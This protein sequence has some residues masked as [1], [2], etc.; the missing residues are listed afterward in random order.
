MGV[1]LF[2]LDKNEKVVSA[3]CVTDIE[4]DETLGETD[5]PVQNNVGKENEKVSDYQEVKSINS[6]DDLSETEGEKA[7][8]QDSVSDVE[9]FDSTNGDEI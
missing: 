4:D 9:D 7:D 5:A 1:I 2:R 3:T 6:S 8:A